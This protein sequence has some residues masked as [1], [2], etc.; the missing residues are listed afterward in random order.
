[1]RQRRAQRGAE[2]TRGYKE[3]VTKMSGLYKEEP[4]GK[5]IPAP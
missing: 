4:L 2:A 5:G 1:M 3:E